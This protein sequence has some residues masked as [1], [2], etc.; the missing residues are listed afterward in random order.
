MS[1]N[2]RVVL[3]TGGGKNLGGLISREMGKK[4]AIVAIHYNSTSSK[5]GA[6]ETVKAI[7]ERGGKA[8]A[9]QA[10]LTKPTGSTQPN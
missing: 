9:F 7:E 1:L 2:G 4:G 3:V 5:A 6:E 8:A 10:D